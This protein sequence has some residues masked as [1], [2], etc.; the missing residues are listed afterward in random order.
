MKEAAQGLGIAKETLA[1]LLNGDARISA[2]MAIR[3]SKGFGG[4]AEHW[5]RQQMQYDLAQIANQADEIN[6]KRLGSAS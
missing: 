1:G 3:L 4:S 5:L 2:E 6:V